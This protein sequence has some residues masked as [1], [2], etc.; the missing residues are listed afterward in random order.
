MVKAFGLIIGLL[1]VLGFSACPPLG[2]STGTPTASP[3]PDE[4]ELPGKYGWA[5]NVACAFLSDK[6]KPG[7]YRNE[8]NN[9]YGCL[10]EAK[11]FGPG[12][13]QNNIVFYARGES[14]WVRQIGVA[15]NVNQKSAQGEAVDL[16]FEYATDM[17]MKAI[18]V[19]LSKH[20]G[21]TLLAGQPGRGFVDTTKVEILRHDFSNGQGYELHFVITPTVNRPQK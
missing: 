6:L 16:L 10:S 17:S 7:V 13:P 20:T 19:P 3:S 14:D 5:P 18:G 9:I 8:G 4:E 21:N 2:N 11:F 1:L 12:K 15:V